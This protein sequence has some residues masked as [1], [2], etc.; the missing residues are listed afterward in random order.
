M[1]ATV[2][3]LNSFAQQFLEPETKGVT[4]FVSGPIIP[5]EPSFFQK[6]AQPW[7]DF[8]GSLVRAGEQYAV[9][10]EEQLPQMLFDKTV[11]E[12][13]GGSQKRVIQ[14]GAG[15]S[16]TYIEPPKSGGAPANP[17]YAVL[18]P[19]QSQADIPLQSAAGSTIGMV[20]VV[21]AIGLAILIALKH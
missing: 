13:F 6:L 19:G 20:I 2:Q 15:K 7:V 3:E 1:T 18:W 11:E 9:K 14:E 10:V 21:I 12:I 5:A 17:F 16:T 8:G 4:T